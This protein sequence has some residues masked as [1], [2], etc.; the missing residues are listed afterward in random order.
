MEPKT[1]PRTILL[2]VTI[3]GN[4][5]ILLP[6]AGSPRVLQHDG[7]ASF[8]TLRELASDPTVPEHRVQASGFDL[9]A[10]ARGLVSLLQDAGRD[11]GKAGG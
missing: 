9:G 10:A 6:P 1:Q 4:V 8:A 7:S 5:L 3:D 11:P 2:V